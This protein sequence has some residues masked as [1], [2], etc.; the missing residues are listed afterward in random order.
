MPCDLKRRTAPTWDGGR[1]KELAKVHS[2][3]TNKDIFLPHHRQAR[4]PSGVT[5]DSEQR[6]C[7]QWERLGAVTAR[8]I[9]RLVVDDDTEAA[10]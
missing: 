6:F 2:L 9:A 8:V 4:Q 10:V 5:P 7:G 3:N 1:S